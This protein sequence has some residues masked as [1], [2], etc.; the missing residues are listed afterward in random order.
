MDDPDPI[1]ITLSPGQVD[2]VLLYA[3]RGTILGGSSRLGDSETIAESLS[4]RPHLSRS[5][6]L[7]IVVLGCFAEDDRM[8]GAGEVARMLGIHEHTALRYIKTLVVAGLLARDPQTRRYRLAAPP[9]GEDEGGRGDEGNRG[10]ADYRGDEGDRGD[11][12]VREGAGDLIEGHAC[13]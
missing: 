8:L 6:T 3:R 4:D 9:S 12:V 1:V 5:L 13:A 11:A 7:G 2:Q 10:D